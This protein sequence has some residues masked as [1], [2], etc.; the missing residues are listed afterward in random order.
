VFV[1][2]DNRK[3]RW[4]HCGYLCTDDGTG[5]DETRDADLIVFELHLLQFSPDV[6]T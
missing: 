2:I 4:I 3:S 5:P 1:V 6:T